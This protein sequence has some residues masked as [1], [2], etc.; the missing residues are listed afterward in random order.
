MISSLISKIFGTANERRLRILR[1]LIG[2]I[3]DL[4]P[5]MVALSDI[6]LSDATN[7]FRQQI[8]KADH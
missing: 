1:P 4:E 6:E 2:R 3:N 8:T 5:K 7:L